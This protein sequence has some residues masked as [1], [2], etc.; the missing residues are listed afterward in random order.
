MTTISNSITGLPHRGPPA[1]TTGSKLLGLFA[2][3]LGIAGLGGVWQSLRTTLAAP[4]WPT[5]VLF[6][7]STAI[8]LLL[9]L[10]Y[11]A[12]GVRGSGAFTKD[13]EHAIYGP[14]AAY[15]PVIGI[16][17]SAHYVQYIHNI[18]RT[19]VVFFVVSLAFLAAQLV[20]HWLLGNLPVETFHPGHLL[21]TVAGAFIASIGLSFSGWPHAAQS[22]SASSSGS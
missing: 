3:P 14:F 4:A 9:T 11:L 21:P 10:A 12:H 22:A 20:A 1:G 8:W 6:G 19:A 17:L 18:A 15:I 5:E 2:I 16:L 7:L 13:R